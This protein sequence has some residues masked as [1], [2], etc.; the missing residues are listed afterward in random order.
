MYG[1]SSRFA[2]ETVQ[3]WFQKIKDKNSPRANSILQRLRNFRDTLGTNQ[4]RMFKVN[5]YLRKFVALI[6]WRDP[7]RSK[8]FLAML[9]VL[10]VLTAAIE[11]RILITI[12]VLFQIS[13]PLRMDNWGQ[14]AGGTHHHPRGFWTRMRYRFWDGIPVPSMS[15]LVYQE[16][17]IRPI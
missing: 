3:S 12:F 7:V 8:I 13:K 5:Q 10:T 16:H 9:L 17:K 2:Q 1:A 6:Q 15:D 11:I 4:R 14:G